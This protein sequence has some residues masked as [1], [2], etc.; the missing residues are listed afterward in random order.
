MEKININ[1]VNFP[2][3]KNIKFKQTER[4]GMLN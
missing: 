3:Q 1:M 2:T 4:Q